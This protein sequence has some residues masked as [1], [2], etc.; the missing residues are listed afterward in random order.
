MRE[1][2]SMR[3]LLS[4]LAHPYEPQEKSMSPS[5]PARHTV[6]VI[7]GGYGGVT[8]AKAL[9]DAADVVLVE[10]RDAFVHNVAALR[11]LVDPDFAPTIFLPYDRLLQNGRV[12]HER[13]ARV[14][15]DRVVLESGEEIP[16]DF[17]V[18]ATGSRYPFPAKPAVDGASESIELLRAAHDALAD[19]RRVLLVGAGPVGLE[20]AG[21][22]VAAFPGVHVTIADVADDI[23]TG[24]FAPELRTELRRQLDELGVELLLGSPLVALP[25]TEPGRL[26]PFTITTEAGAEVSADMWFRC[27][28]VAP[29]SDYLGEEL[30]GALTADGFIEVTPDLRVAGQERVFAIG[31]VSTADRK[32][33]AWATAQAK[34]VAANILA[35]SQ[36]TGELTSY[37]T[38]PTAIAVPL[39]PEGGAGQFP[40][41][42]SIVGAET[43][44]E[45]KGRHMM[46]A[47]YAE[48]MGHGVPAKA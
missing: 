21:E 22:I 16:A 8:A 30:A 33:A 12:V 28:G 42:E 1:N 46:V 32:M 44:A 29:V 2:R 20:L 35:L 40:G 39:G 3:V 10:P 48:L 6:A 43:V 23:L 18:L 5:S 34:V 7:G 31:D 15:T 14:E 4:L 45:V 26:E 13:A 25:A 11:A 27:Y 24:P 37:E 36:G 17:I 41:Q 47:P 19:S 38:A 9:D